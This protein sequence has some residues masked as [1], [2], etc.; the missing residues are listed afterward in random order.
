MSDTN[1]SS[2]LEQKF[3]LLDQENSEDKNYNAKKALVSAIPA[4]GSLLVTFYETYIK[5]P[6]SQRLHN[7]LE[8]LVQ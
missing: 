3:Y 4:V 6:S 7:F 2:E 5:E 1:N 8:E